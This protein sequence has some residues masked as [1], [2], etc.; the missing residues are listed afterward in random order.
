MALFKVNTGCREQEVCKLRWEW[1][2]EVPELNTSVFLI[3]A[4]FGGRTE[5]S[6]VK[7][8][9]DRLVVLN[10]IAASVIHG[11][12]GKHDELVF[13]YGDADEARALHRMN[14][15]AWRSARERAAK[16]WEED[17]G[18]KAD[19]GFASVRI[20]DLKHT[21]GRRL[22]AANVAF[23]DRQVLLGHKSGSV[24]TH[25]SG[26]ELAALIEAA[27]KVA[28]TESRSPTLTILKR[29]IA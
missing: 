19:R 18:Q 22:R 27:K 17:K 11:Q 7:N 14:D 10:N 28:G 4:D 26:A 8:G 3:P 12:R 15:T 21:F 24:T 1:E 2:V 16:K 20:H 23:E 29:R 9:D 13:P 25:Y 6:G 5:K